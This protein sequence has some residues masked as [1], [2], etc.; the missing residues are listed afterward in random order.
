VLCSNHK[1]TLWICSST[2]LSYRTPSPSIPAHLPFPRASNRSATRLP[3]GV[4]SFPLRASSAIFSS[5]ALSRLLT[6]ALDGVRVAFL[7]RVD[8][9]RFAGVF[10]CLRR[11]SAGLR[12]AG[13]FGSGVFGATVDL[14]VGASAALGVNGRLE[15]EDSGLGFGGDGVLDSLMGVRSLVGVPS[16]VYDCFTSVFVEI[17]VGVFAVAFGGVITGIFE[18]S[19]SASA[20]LRSSSCHS[21]SLLAMSTALADFCSEE[22]LS[23]HGV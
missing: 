7:S 19:V 14:D 3:L 17:L 10:G 23:T 8:V 2:S 9:R 5:I 6:I 13:V 22:R 12:A 1:P 11:A 21:L 20:L 16:G 15:L 4:N 18:R